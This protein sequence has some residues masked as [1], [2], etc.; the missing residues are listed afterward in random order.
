[1]NR[2]CSRIFCLA[3]SN[4]TS[5]LTLAAL[6]YDGLAQR[7]NPNTVVSIH[8]LKVLGGDRISRQPVSR[9]FTGTELIGGC[10]RG[11]DGSIRLPCERFD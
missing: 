3:L 7:R 10:G 8:H 11:Q 5:S 9:T 6:V 2:L 1:M 4:V